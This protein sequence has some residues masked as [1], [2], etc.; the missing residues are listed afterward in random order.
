VR[1]LGLQNEAAAV[2]R[3]VQQRHPADFWVNYN[4]GDALAA[5]GAP[6][7]YPGEGLGYCRAAVAI[8]PTSAYAHSVLGVALFNKGDTEA[9]I[10]AYQQA[11]ALDP[12][13]TW[14]RGAL[15]GALRR[16]GD[17][18]G[19]IA[20]FK[21]GVELDPK[22]PK[23]RWDLVLE[24]RSQGKRDEAMACFKEW[25]AEAHE[26]IRLKPDD[27]VPHHYLGHA[28]YGL[29]RDKEAEAEYREA[30]RLKPDSPAP[31][32][33][34]AWFLATCPDLKLRDPGQALIHARKA[35]ELA[36]GNFNYLNTLGVALYR[37]GDWQ[38]AIEAL[39][40]CTQQG[41]SS[42]DFFFLAMAHGKLN[43]KEKARSWYDQAVA[44]MDK[45]EPQNEEL[46][47]FRVE[48]AALLGLAKSAESQEKKE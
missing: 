17:L 10:G 2:L 11:L 41:G 36:P 32:N 31:H 25:E 33:S 28:L 8:R 39:M 22:N 3:Q 12:K 44:S 21:K 9:A 26:A 15:A 47:R 37:N 30:S 14:V 38:A 29:G 48:A 5:H 27:A 42:R 34:L 18:N 7:Q 20:C 40:K 16:K 13:C 19:A 1:S 45:N 6:Q 24:L 43:E 4:L 46:K 35:V 23:A